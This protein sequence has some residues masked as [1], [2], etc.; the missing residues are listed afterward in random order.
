MK[1]IKKRIRTFGIVALS[2][3]FTGGTAALAHRKLGTKV[4]ASPAVKV[5]LTGEAERSG[6]RVP[7]EQAGLA[8]P[9][10]IIYW[11]I[12]SANEG[13]AS[14]REYTAVGQIPPG[15]SFVAGSASAEG[16]AA[17]TYSIDGGNTF[18]TQPMI[19]ERQPGGSM[20]QVAAPVSMYTQVRYQ[21]PTPL[22]AGY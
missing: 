11:A 18:S 22:N 19:E 21:W 16:G 13:D 12:T 3:V 6:E 20:K 1:K 2:V 7:V 4:S 9:G 5:L 8:K 10:E 17:I 15:T 14:A